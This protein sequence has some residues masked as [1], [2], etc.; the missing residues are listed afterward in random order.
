MAY[1]MIYKRLYSVAAELIN[2]RYR[3][4]IFTL[5]TICYRISHEW[6]ISQLAQLLLNLLRCTSAVVGH[7]M[8]CVNTMLDSN[9][10]FIYKSYYKAIR[11]GVE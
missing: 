11:R 2:Y 8:T 4:E 10:I 6:S 7:F 9:A 3:E 5:R 1:S